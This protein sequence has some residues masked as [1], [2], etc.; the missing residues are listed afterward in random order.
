M[1]SYL[2]ELLQKSCVLDVNSLI[3]NIIEARDP[4]IPITIRKHLED[5]L[6][7]TFTMLNQL[8]GVSEFSLLPKR[9][10][11]SEKHSSTKEPKKV[12]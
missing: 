12:F 3:P 5:K 7:S 8:D 10:G 4:L 1:C 9:G 6:Q 11:E 2:R